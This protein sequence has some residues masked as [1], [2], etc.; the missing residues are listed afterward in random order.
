MLTAKSAATRSLA[1]KRGASPATLIGF[2]ETDLE[3]TDDRAESTGREE[4]RPERARRV[5]ADGREG[6]KGGPDLRR[7]VGE[8]PAGLVVDDLWP[9]GSRQ[10]GGFDG[11]RRGTQCMRA[12]V[13]DAYGLTGGPGSRGGCGRTHLAGRHAADEAAAD[14]LGNVQLATGERP[15]AGDGRARTIVSGSFGLEQHQDPLCAI[16]RPG[17][18]KAPVGF[19]ERLWR[20]HRPT[21]RSRPATSRS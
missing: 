19:A 6:A 20:S 4:P 18:D 14:L 15:S 9:I 2:G 12:H 21:L 8:L 16:G 11:I 3:V 17:G 10:N 13:A 1:K 5:L 7:H